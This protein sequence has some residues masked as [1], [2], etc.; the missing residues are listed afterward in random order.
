MGIY[1]GIRHHP[2]PRT[3]KPMGR[4]IKIQATTVRCDLAGEQNVVE[5]LRTVKARRGWNKGR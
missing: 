5:V 3:H 1:T 4:W 2:C